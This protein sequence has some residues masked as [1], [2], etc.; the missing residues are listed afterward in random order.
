MKH[1]RMNHF[2]SN[3]NMIGGSSTNSVQTRREI[4]HWAGGD[5]MLGWAMKEGNPRIGVT[6]NLQE[7]PNSGG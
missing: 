5:P 3:V 4:L 7:T 2:D 6:E 1:L